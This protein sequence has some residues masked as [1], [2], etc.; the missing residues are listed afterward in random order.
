MTDGRR[1]RGEQRRAALVG[2][3]VALVREGG[4][5]A[6][7]HRAVAARAG[8][9]LSATTYYFADLD[10]LLAAAGAEL[11]EQWAAHARAVAAR[12]RSSAAQALV[13]AVLPP[14]DDRVLRGHY[15]HL[16]GAGRLPALAG[17][18]ARGRAALDAAIAGL[19]LPWPTEV[20]VALV[21]GA[22]LAAL[23]EGRD[24][25]AHAREVVARVV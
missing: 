23:S 19:G 13:D 18:Y 6:V 5:A 11:A 9:S 2:A 17:A 21:D 22:A 10:E 24:V 20:L 4:P 8:A 14:G 15:E 7:S 3:A 16:A 1:A 25:R 12:E